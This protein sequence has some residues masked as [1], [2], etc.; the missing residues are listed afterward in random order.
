MVIGTLKESAEL[1]WT[2]LA[3]FESNYKIRTHILNVARDGQAVT[4]ASGGMKVRLE[5]I[6]LFNRVKA[7]T[8]SEFGEKL[9]AAV[10]ARGEERPP[11]N[12]YR[13][14]FRKVN[15]A[16]Q[17]AKNGEVTAKDVQRW[18]AG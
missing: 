6:N 4:R 16:R 17:E 8:M 5:D 9:F 2:I 7:T 11:H 12:T 15:E 18:N 3:F 1:R 13:E 14:L 10:K